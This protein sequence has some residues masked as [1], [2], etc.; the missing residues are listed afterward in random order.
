[1]IVRVLCAPAQD[2]GD[3]WDAVTAAMEDKDVGE[4]FIHKAEGKYMSDRREREVDLRKRPEPVGA[5]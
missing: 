2:E 1:M 4:I 3:L 5:C